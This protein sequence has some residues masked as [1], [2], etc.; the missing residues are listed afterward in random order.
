[1]LKSVLESIEIEVL[2][3]NIRKTNTK[4]LTSD[5][6]KKFITLYIFLVL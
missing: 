1:M 4:N 2:E 6:E 3:I 5:F